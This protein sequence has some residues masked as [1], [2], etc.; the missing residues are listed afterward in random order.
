MSI[1]VYVD[2]QEGT[3]GLQIHERLAGRADLDV[4]KIDPEKRK[5]PAARKELLNAADLVFFCLPDAA[6]REAAEMIENPKTRMID[7]STAF[8]THP[9]WAYGIPELSPSQREKIRTAKRVSN[10]GCHA[11]GF[12][13]ALYPLVAK[14][15]VPADLPL[16]CTSVTG[17]S[18]AGKKMIEKY[19]V[20]PSPLL[21]IPRHYALGLSHKHLPEMQ[22]ALGLSQPPLFV[23]IIANFYEG[24]GV[25]IPLFNSQLKG[26]PGAAAVREILAE[27]YAGEPFVRVMPYG[28]SE[29]LDDGFMPITACNHTNRIDIFVFGNDSQILLLSRFDNLGKGASGAAVQNMNLMLGLP[30]TLGLNA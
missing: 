9:D 1:R 8:R 19:E 18:G 25:S 11:T 12:I 29:G 24:M 17:Y 6:S 14:G 28:T 4:L 5:D 2:G 21:A 27:H 7:A 20:N 16:S 30:E 15:V 3:T 13:M 26:Q 22:A 10:P 23:P